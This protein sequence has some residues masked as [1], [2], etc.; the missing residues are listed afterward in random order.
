MRSLTADEASA[1][2]RAISVDSYDLA[3]DLTR[4]SEQFGSRSEI[5]FRSLDGSATFLDLQAA[6]VTSITLN[7][8]DIDPALVEDGRLS[9]DRLAERN[10]LVVDALMTYSHDGEGMHR[11]IDPEDKQAYIYA[12]AF[13]TAAP[14]IFACFEQPDLK[15]I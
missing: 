4:G 10:T 13:L 15:A 1:R 2:A 7:G 11:A 6:E 8:Q 14:R 9:L 5:A 3:L 12:M